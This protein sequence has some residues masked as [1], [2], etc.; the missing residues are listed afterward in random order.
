MK[1]SSIWIYL[2]VCLYNILQ[3]LCLCSHSGS[4]MIESAFECS[5][6]GVVLRCCIL[7]CPLEMDHVTVWRCLSVLLSECVHFFNFFFKI[8]YMYTLEGP[9]IIDGLYEMTSLNICLINDI[10]HFVM[11]LV[12]TILLSS[13]SLQILLTCIFHFSFACLSIWEVYA[14]DPI[15]PYLL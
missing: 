7:I 10:N 6:P 13:Y 3:N 1:S 2:S 15:S 9:W 11:F 8:W 4:L 12:F 14:S 5:Q